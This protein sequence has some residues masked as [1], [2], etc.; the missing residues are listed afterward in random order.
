VFEPHDPGEEKAFSEKRERGGR[1]TAGRRKRKDCGIF[2]GREE[3]SK[4][5]GEGRVN[6]VVRGNV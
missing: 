4:V 2:T 6:I 5:K 3:T 1:M